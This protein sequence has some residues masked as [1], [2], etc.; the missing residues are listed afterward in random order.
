MSAFFAVD[1]GSTGI[2]KIIVITHNATIHCVKCRPLSLVWTGHKAELPPKTFKSLTNWQNIAKSFFHISFCLTNDAALVL[3]NSCLSSMILHDLMADLSTLFI[4]AT[5][6]GQNKATIYI[7]VTLLY[8]HFSFSSEATCLCLFCN[9][10]F[11]L[12]LF[13]IKIF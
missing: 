10:F 7:A 2:G 6:F 12:I 3:H 4:L 13:L 8:I 9:N 5:F 1:W 11:L